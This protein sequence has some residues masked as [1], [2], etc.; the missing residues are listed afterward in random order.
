MKQVL[1]KV[2]KDI[3]KKYDIDEYA[4]KKIVIYD[5]TRRHCQKKH[6]KEFGNPKTFYY[7]MNNLEDIINNPDNVFYI[8]SKDILEYYKTFA[9]GITVRVKIQPGN[10][11]KVKTV[12][13]VSQT[14]I[15]NRVK[16]EQYNKYVINNENAQ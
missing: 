13:T 7:I 3:A 8:K 2:S 6:L 1:G 5:D 12:F 4:N 11:L 10:E 15:D 9:F 16:R 14:K